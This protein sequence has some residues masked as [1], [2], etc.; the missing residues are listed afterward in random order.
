[1]ADPKTMTRAER[2][3]KGAISR[4]HEPIP[5]ATH[6]GILKIGGQEIQCDVLEDGRRVL[7]QKT[8]LAAIGRGK[9]GGKQRR[10]LVA[11][12]LPV[13]VQADNLTPYFEKDFIQ[14]ALPITYRG[15]DSRRYIAYDAPVLPEVCK[16]YVKAEHDDALQENQKKI[17]AVCKAMICGLATVGITALVDDATGYVYER[18]R[19]ELQKILENYIEKE[20]LPWTKKFPDEF[21]EQVYR[22]HG[23]IWPKVHKN[24]P[25]YVGKFINDYIYNSLPPMVVEEL[26]RINPANENGNRKHRHH[27]WLTESF[28]QKALEKRVIKVTAGLQFADNLDQFKNFMER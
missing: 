10:G 25:Q 20:L 5:K 6:T 12:N 3:R 22:L 1:M 4:W 24:H 26:K 19:N 14:R 23:W 16:I 18:E 7:R 27:Q 2:S 8:F 15:V 21:F 17:A 28:G 9:V 13:F 11:T